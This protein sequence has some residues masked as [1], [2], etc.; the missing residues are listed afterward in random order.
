MRA[1]PIAS[2]R[3]V[4]FR[5][6]AAWSCNQCSRWIFR[7]ASDLGCGTVV[8]SLAPPQTDGHLRI[9]REG[10]LMPPRNVALVDRLAEGKRCEPGRC[11]PAGSRHGDDARHQ[12]EAVARD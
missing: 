4:A 8:L 7:R 10:H 12:A 2:C 6:I 3:I 9:S 5:G 11:V 1:V